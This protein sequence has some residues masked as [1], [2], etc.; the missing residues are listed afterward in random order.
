MKKNGQLSSRTVDHVMI[1][2]KTYGKKVKK[3]GSTYW[4]RTN[5]RCVLPLDDSSICTNERTC[6]SKFISEWQI[7]SLLRLRFATSV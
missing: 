3:Y 4:T 1:K 7:L 6:T 5:I 2:L